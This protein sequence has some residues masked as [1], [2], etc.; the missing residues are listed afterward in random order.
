MTRNKWRQKITSF[1]VIMAMVIT[2][3]SPMGA[4]AAEPSYAQDAET[5]VKAGK[6]VYTDMGL[7]SGW[8]SSTN[9]YDFIWMGEYK[10]RGEIAKVPLKWRVLDNQTNTAESGYFLLSDGSIETIYFEK[11]GDPVDRGGYTEYIY[12][13]FWA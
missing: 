2:C 12:S 9:S 1:L 4:T 11:T 8:D 5:T 3:I 10:K 7:I 13:T 6:A